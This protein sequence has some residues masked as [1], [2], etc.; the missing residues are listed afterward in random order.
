MAIFCQEKDNFNFGTPESL[1]TTGIQSIWLCSDCSKQVIFGLFAFV[2]HLC[3]GIL[4]VCSAL[5][6]S[7]ETIPTIP[8]SSKTIPEHSELIP[9]ASLIASHRNALRSRILRVQRQQ[10]Q[11]VLRC[12]SIISIML[13]RAAQQRSAAATKGSQQQ[14][15]EAQQHSYSSRNHSYHSSS[16]ATAKRQKVHRQRPFSDP[17]PNKKNH[18]RYATCGVYAIYNPTPQHILC[19]NFTPLCRLSTH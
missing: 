10:L 9:I 1:A 7:F 8:T 6:L 19:A 11:F 13:S 14:K 12:C 3:L 17:H 5:V 2:G 4:K 16:T 15:Q 18:F